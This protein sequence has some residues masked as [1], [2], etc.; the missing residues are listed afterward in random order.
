MSDIP[1]ARW[2]GVAIYSLAAVILLPLLFSDPVDPRSTIRSRFDG[3]PTIGRAGVNQQ[4]PVS[5]PVPDVLQA[6]AALA[7]ASP[8]KVA[9]AE[10][11]ANAPQSTTGPGHVEAVAPNA[12]SSTVRSVAAS[13]N[14]ASWRLQL[15]S[16]TDQASAERFVKLL[17]ADGYQPQVIGAQVKGRRVWRVSVEIVGN[18]ADAKGL[19]A[20]LDKRYKLKSALFKL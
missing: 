2:V 17:R 1:K 12:D 18:T 14:P 8:S 10:P 15:A 4:T 7:V 6:R 9:A 5:T 19:Q 11:R 13:A 20:R 3:A 16:Y